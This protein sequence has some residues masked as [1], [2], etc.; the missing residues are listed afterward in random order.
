MRFQCG[1]RQTVDTMSVCTQEAHNVLQGSFFF[2]TSH[3]I[4]QDIISSEMYDV[5]I[6]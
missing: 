1:R 6:W 3:L 4:I 2:Y 5:D